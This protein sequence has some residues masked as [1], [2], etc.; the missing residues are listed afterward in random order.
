MSTADPAL[1]SDLPPDL[2]PD[3]PPDL[4]DEIAAMM[5]AT[6]HPHGV[7]V[8][9]LAAV[10]ARFGWVSDAH[11]VELARLIGVSAAELDGVATYF[12]LIFRRPVGRHVIM[13]CDSVSCWLMGADALR[14]RLCD[15]LGI[16]PGQTTPDGAATLLPIVCLGHCDHAP[17]LLVDRTLHGDLDESRIDAIA[18]G[19]RA[20]EQAR[21]RA[22]ERGTERGRE[23]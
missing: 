22:R 21:E 20:K 2:S 13:M 23:P 17:A 10:Q 18:D 12:N 14:A 7:T 19:V 11:L 6:D 9:A 1:P 5:A 3:L 4:R 8:G 15:R 16:Q